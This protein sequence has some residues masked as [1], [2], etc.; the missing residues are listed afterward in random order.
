MKIHR[1]INSA[2]AAT[3]FNRDEIS[4][5]Q[6]STVRSLSSLGLFSLSIYSEICSFWRGHLT[7]NRVSVSVAVIVDPTV[8]ARVLEFVHVVV[9]GSYVCKGY[10]IHTV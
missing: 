4:K 9:V 6:T 2:T 10:S 8:D 3:A 1:A 7:L 5:L